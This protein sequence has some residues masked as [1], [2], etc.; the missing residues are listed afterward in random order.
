MF[1]FTIL[2]TEFA[3][4]KLYLMGQIITS[5][6][7]SPFGHTNLQSISHHTRFSPL[8]IHDT[9]WKEQFAAS[10]NIYK[11]ILSPRYNR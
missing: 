8:Y 3:N 6:H 4:V 7:L 2:L 11:K 1:A 10:Q 9:R 5:V